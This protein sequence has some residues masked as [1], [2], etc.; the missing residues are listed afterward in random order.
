MLNIM[1]NGK[2]AEIVFALLELTLKWE[3]HIMSK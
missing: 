3:R 2:H 1:D